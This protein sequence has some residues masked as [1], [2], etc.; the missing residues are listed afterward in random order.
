MILFPF[1]PLRPTKPDSHFADEYNAAQEME[2]PTALI[3]HDAAVAGAFARSCKKVPNMPATAVYRGWMLK[4]DAYEGFETALNERQVTLRTSV[5]S[6]RMAHHLPR[7]FDAVKDHTPQSAWTTTDS[8]GELLEA[9]RRLP[10][11][12]A[13][14]KDY[15]KSEKHYWHEAMFIPDTS[16]ESNALNIAARFRE[17]RGESFDV[18]YV[19]RSYERFEGPELRSWWVDGRCVLVTPHPDA[20]PDQHIDTSIDVTELQP[21]ISRIGA[22]FV[23]ADV[24][25]SAEDGVLRIV[26]IG[27]GQVSDR[28]SAIDAAKFISSIAQ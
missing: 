16:E 3:D 26:E 18:G 8:E 24:V 28:P 15:S 4:P 17:L 21:A 13:V 5:A 2:I 23:T 27:D 14:L 10:R 11:G 20:E 12:A 1:D 7:W 22:S 25:R 19:V 9:L 6:Y